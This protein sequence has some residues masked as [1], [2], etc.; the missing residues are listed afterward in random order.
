M[1]ILT[2]QAI[3]FVAL[4]LLVIGAALAFSGVAV[5]V[6]TGMSAVGTGILIAGFFASKNTKE[7]EPKTSKVNPAS[8]TELLM[9]AMA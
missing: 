1:D 6:G 2:H 4:A 9:L 3:Q 7:D 5:G 8:N